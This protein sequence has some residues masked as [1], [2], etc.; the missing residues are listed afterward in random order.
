MTVSKIEDVSPRGHHNVNGG[1]HG[2]D[3]ECNCS[4]QMEISADALRN[5]PCH[6]YH[7]SPDRLQAFLPRHRRYWPH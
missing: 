6:P 4:D 7:P 3:G 1:K 5:H 2:A